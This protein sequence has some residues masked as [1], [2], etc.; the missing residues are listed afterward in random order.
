MKFPSKE[1]SYLEGNFI[2]RWETAKE[3][4]GEDALLV[5][6]FV[7]IFPVFEEGSQIRQ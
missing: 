3:V 1:L 5:V 6:S 7:F 2:K 4:L